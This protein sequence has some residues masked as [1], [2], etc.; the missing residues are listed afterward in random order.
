MYRSV[1]FNKI[2]SKQFLAW[3]QNFRL[4]KKTKLFNTLIYIFNNMDYISP[5]KN[6]TIENNNFNLFSH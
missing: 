2:R 4:K 1:I 6:K 3:Y 5:L